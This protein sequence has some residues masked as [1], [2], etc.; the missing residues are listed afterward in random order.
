M[1]RRVR[2]GGLRSRHACVRRVAN[3]SAAAFERRSRTPPLAAKRARLDQPQAPASEPEDVA[4]T[5]MELMGGSSSDTAE[6]GDDERSQ[7]RPPGKR[8]RDS[9]SSETPTQAPEPTAKARRA[10]PASYP[11]PFQPTNGAVMHS[12]PEFF[13]DQHQQ[14]LQQQH[15]AGH[16]AYVGAPAQLPYWRMLAP[17]QMVRPSHPLPPPLPPSRLL[18]APAPPVARSR[19]TRPTRSSSCRRAVLGA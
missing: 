14:L 17:G 18:T 12:A 9:I 1:L 16:L 7:V 13:Y 8:L 10:E 15:R 4:A 6:S 19:D 5:L 3:T 2:Q 11:A